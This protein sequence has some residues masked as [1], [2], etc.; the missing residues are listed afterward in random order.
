[1]DSTSE[2]VRAVKE[3]FESEGYQSRFT[4]DV[5]MDLIAKMDGKGDSCMGCGQ[6]LEGQ[7]VFRADG[8]MEFDES[9]KGRPQFR[10][11]KRNLV[12]QL[13]ADADA[14]ERMDGID[15]VDLKDSFVRIQI[16]PKHLTQVVA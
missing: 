10:V 8:G 2:L 11:D 1:M 5:V 4:E 12:A 15:S 16:D 6:V 14:I 7:V 13:R 9:L 3:L